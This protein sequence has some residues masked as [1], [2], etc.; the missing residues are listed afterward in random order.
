MALTYSTSMCFPLWLV[1]MHYHLAGK[2]WYVLINVYQSGHESHF[3]YNSIT[4]WRTS[5]SSMTWSSN[6]QQQN[7]CHDPTRF[8]IK[9]YT[10]KHMPWTNT[11]CICFAGLCWYWRDNKSFEQHQG[12]CWLHLLQRLWLRVCG[13]S[14]K[15]RPWSGGLELAGGHDSGQAC[16]HCERH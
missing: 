11:A 4:A 12:R 16:L 8:D 13:S 7:T 15:L 5:G 9:Q 10:A 3:T 2:P 14:G 1:N 6:H